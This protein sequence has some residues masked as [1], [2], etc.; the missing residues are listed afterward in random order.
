MQQ[1]QEKHC[2]QI[3]RTRV[4][5][6]SPTKSQGQSYAYIAISEVY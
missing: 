6:I 1:V 2:Q 5:E 3:H 4:W